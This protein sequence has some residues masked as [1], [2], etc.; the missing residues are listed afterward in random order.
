MDIHQ[1]QTKLAYQF[2]DLSLLQQA[3][4]HRSYGR[5]NYERL[6]FV[7]D[8][9]LDYVIG[10]N[11]YHKYPECPEGELSKMRAALVNQETLVDIANQ[12]E[13]GRY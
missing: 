6:E 13:L 2:K 10:L 11:L 12:L 8:G 3:L 5:H 9:I 7:G 4:T 1:L